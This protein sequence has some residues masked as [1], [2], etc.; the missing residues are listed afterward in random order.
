MAPGPDDKFKTIV[1]RHLTLHVARI[2]YT[3]LQLFEPS[4]RQCLGQAVIGVYSLFLD[5][6]QE[7][8]VYY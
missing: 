7:Q 5:P 3:M 6:Y 8:Y 4:F 1:F 2:F